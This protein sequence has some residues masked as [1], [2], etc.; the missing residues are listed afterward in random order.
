MKCL[1]ANLL[2]HKVGLIANIHLHRFFSAVVMSLDS[3]EATDMDRLAT[4]LEKQVHVMQS[5]V[6]WIRCSKV[7]APF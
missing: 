6:I 1:V 3:S 2:L 7:T 4:R 5:E